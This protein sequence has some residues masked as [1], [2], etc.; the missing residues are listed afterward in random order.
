MEA[1]EL[2][3][4][5]PLPRRVLRFARLDGC[6]GNQIIVVKQINKI[7]IIGPLGGESQETVPRRPRPARRTGRR[8][9]RGRRTRYK[10]RRRYHQPYRLRTLRLPERARRRRRRQRCVCLG[11]FVIDGGWGKTACRRADSDSS[12]GR[13]PLH[14]GG[15]RSGG[16]GGRGSG[17]AAV[18]AAAVAWNPAAEA[19]DRGEPTG[20]EGAAGETRYGV[21]FMRAGPSLPLGSVM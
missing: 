19:E 14:G 17:D 9:N 6:D 12:K 3:Y 20:E 4:L 18:P 8:I 2:I 13:P 21:A 15:G 16:G 11:V 10:Q 1:H 7:K 5:R